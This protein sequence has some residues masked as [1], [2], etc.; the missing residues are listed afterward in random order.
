MPGLLQEGL[1]SSFIELNCTSVVGEQKARSRFC[2]NERIGGA[3]PSIKPSAEHG[4][5]AALYH[6][7]ELESSRGRQ[8][9]T[10]QALA[11]ARE[12]RKRGSKPDSYTPSR[13][14]TNLLHSRR[15]WR[16]RFTLPPRSES[17]SPSGK[18]A[19]PNGELR[20][21]AGI[22]SCISRFHTL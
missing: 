10:L 15:V 20:F 21:R 3:A 7:Q 6:Y 22:N 8:P 12:R 13:K 14:R 16:A 1:A 2:P 9:G 5:I 19:K 11:V 4:S 18:K 17:V